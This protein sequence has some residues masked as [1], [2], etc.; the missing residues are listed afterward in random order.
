M[1]YCICKVLGICVLSLVNLSVYWKL[2]SPKQLLL[3]ANIL[4]KALSDFLKRLSFE[5]CIN[6]IISDRATQ[7]LL[8]DSIRFTD[9]IPPKCIYIDLLYINWIAIVERL[10]LWW[11]CVI[12]PIAAWFIWTAVIFINQIMILFQIWCM[13]CC[14]MSQT[15]E[16][17]GNR[18]RSFL[19]YYDGNLSVQV[20]ERE[21][22]RA[23]LDSV[24]QLLRA[25]DDWRRSKHFYK[26]KHS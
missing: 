21:R 16:R 22:C 19:L 6:I 1:Y 14:C 9:S 24:H 3:C 4:N 13:L 18:D 10:L 8:T 20:I 26:I 2:L 17:I 5:H 12:G 15:S 7:A 11:M 25:L 23:G